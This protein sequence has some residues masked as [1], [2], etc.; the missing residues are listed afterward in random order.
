MKVHKNEATLHKLVNKDQN[1]EWIADIKLQCIMSIKKEK[2]TDC[3]KI[4]PLPDYIN[5]VNLKSEHLLVVYVQKHFSFS[6]SKI[7]YRAN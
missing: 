7:F 2:L 4:P 1:A 3:D 6:K 5:L